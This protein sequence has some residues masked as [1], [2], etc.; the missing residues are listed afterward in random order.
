MNDPIVKSLVGRIQF[1]H[2]KIHESVLHLSQPELC[3]QPSPTA[4]PIGW[5]IFHIVRWADMFQASF[6]DQQHVWDRDNLASDSGLESAN[7][8][9]LQTGATLS[10]HEATH[11]PLSIGKDRLTQYTEVVFGLSTDALKQITLDDLY[12]SRESILRI[13]FSTKPISEGKGV[14]VLLVDD[15]SFHISHA[16][17]HLGMIE[18][19][20]GT[21]FNRSGTATI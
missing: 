19:L 11:I 12:T 4:P 21:M 20:I 15:I 3:Q 17:R 16:S 10:P 13:D 18:A 5:H 6:P 2:H 14:D 9:L 8:G 1:A 7:L